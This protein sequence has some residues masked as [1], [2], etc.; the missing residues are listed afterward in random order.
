M[1]E[2]FCLSAML[3]HAHV[4]VYNYACQRNSV[5]WIWEEERLKKGEIK[6]E[7][8]LYKCWCRRSPACSNLLV[9]ACTEV[10]LRSRNILI[11]KLHVLIPQQV[12]PH[13]ELQS[14]CAQR[15][16]LSVNYKA[17]QASIHAFSVG[18]EPV[19]LHIN[20]AASEAGVT[21]HSFILI[22]GRQGDC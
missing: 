4:Y 18:R 21:V 8:D 15:L 10:L 12:V 17:V 6:G 14:A 16:E 20:V 1:K 2:I 3:L 11:L 9:P 22:T 5:G 7:G 13:R 19:L